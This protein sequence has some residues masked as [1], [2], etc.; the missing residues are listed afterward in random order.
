[1]L[2]QKNVNIKVDGTDYEVAVTWKKVKRMTLRI[3][4]QGAP[5][6]SV[7]LRTPDREIMKFLTSCGSWIKKNA[8]NRDFFS[9]PERLAE[10]DEVLLLGI[11]RRMTIMQGNRAAIELCP[12]GAVLYMRGE[13]EDPV[14]AAAA[15][16][17]AL[18]QFAM[19]LFEMRFRIYSD[20]IPAGHGSPVLKIRD[21]TSRWGSANSNTNEIHLSIHLIKTP[22]ACIDSVI[23]HEAVHFTHMDH[24][25]GFY[26]MLL[27]RMPD[28]KDRNEMLKRYA[29][30]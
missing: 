28:Y 17:R 19:Q 15:Y 9:F 16:R 22:L 13:R 18:Q 2:K 30:S 20:V 21:M 14:K 4:R 25:S 24:G 7:P 26:S 6:L 11:R 10:G 27:A 3:D 1:M 12:D 29:R 8:G 23:L 5:C